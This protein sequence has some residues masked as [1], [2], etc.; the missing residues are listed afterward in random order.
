MGKIVATWHV[1][2]TARDRDEGVSRA[3][4]PL[5]DVEIN[6]P[7]NSDLEALVIAGIQAG[8]EGIEVTAAAE[9]TDI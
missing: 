3:N 1:K 2:V 5:P 7:T 6:I 9:R 8:V 4:T